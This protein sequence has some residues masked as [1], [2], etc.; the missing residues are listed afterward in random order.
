[1]THGVL[2]PGAAFLQKPF[3]V[4]ELVGR[5]RDVLDREEA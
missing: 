4:E 5:L 3:S 1:M 2:S